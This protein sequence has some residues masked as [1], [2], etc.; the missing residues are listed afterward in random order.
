MLLTYHLQHTLPHHFSM[1]QFISV[2]QVLS[3]GYIQ[4]VS[5]PGVQNLYILLQENPIRYI[6]RRVQ[7]LFILPIELGNSIPSIEWESGVYIIGVN[8]A[9]KCAHIFCT[10]NKQTG[11]INSDWSI[12]HMY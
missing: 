11:K 3:M 2:P 1:A 12:L 10:T 6:R 7:L 4:I 5:S 9:G 8:R